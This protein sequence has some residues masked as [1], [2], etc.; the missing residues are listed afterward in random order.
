M[1][2]KFVADVLDKLTGFSS[3]DTYF[4]SRSFEHMLSGFNCEITPRGAYIWLFA[5]PLF[6]RSDFLHLSYSERMPFPKGFIDFSVIPQA[7]L[8]DEFLLRIEGLAES[9]GTPLALANFFQKFEKEPRLLNNE[10]LRGTLGFAKVLANDVDAAKEHLSAVLSSS[11]ELPWRKDVS[12]VYEK[13]A[14]N[15]LGGA[16]KLVTGFENMTKQRLGIENL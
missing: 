16:I 4:F 3:F 6:D 8:T 14:A 5:Y 12:N 10:R 2:K 7:R 15:D 1:K 9:A 11:H 13:L